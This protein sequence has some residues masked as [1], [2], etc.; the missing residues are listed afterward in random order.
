MLCW[1]RSFQEPKQH[2]HKN[3][4]IKTLLFREISSIFLTKNSLGAK[5][6]LKANFV[7]PS[8]SINLGLAST[9]S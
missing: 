6:F 2:S 3:P 5:L 4:Q 1:V 9:W 8:F 7:P